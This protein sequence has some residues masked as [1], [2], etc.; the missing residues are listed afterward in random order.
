VHGPQ[1]SWGMPHAMVVFLSITIYRELE[2]ECGK[3]NLLVVV[4]QNA[5]FR[6]HASR[7]CR[8]VRRIGRFSCGIR[9]VDDICTNHI[10][11]VCMG[12]DCVD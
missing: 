9:Y 8:L 6:A 5:S 12:V 3:R 2:F 10:I 7:G 4:A 11:L 1:I